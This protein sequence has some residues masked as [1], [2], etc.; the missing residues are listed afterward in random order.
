[1]CALG[2]QV[3]VATYPLHRAREIWQTAFIKVAHKRCAGYSTIRSHIEGRS[4]LEFG[5]PSPIFS[6]NHL[7][8]IYSIA[9]SIDSCN[10]AP[11]TLWSRRDISRRFGPRLGQQFILEASDPSGIADGF[12]DFVAASHVLEHV[13]NSLRA[14]HEWKRILKSGGTLLVVVPHKPHTFDHRRPF[15]T[16]DHIKADFESNVSEEDLTHLDEIIA[17]HDLD[18]DRQAGSLQ[19]FRQRCL[20]NASH[21]AIHHHVFSPEVLVEMFSF[22]QMK[23]VHVSVERPHHIIVQ[24][25]KVP[26]TTILSSKTEEF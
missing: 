21:R 19:Q 18:L 5:G 3:M 12:Y 15:T 20:L 17:L 14:L 23:V 26:T 11:Q 16:F 4:G 22:L 2:N 9:A 7:V 25:Q 10:F 8:P 1:M 24:A 13:A 6:A